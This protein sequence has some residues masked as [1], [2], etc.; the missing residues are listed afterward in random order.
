[1]TFGLDIAVLKTGDDDDLKIASDV[2]FLLS[3][4][5]QRSRARAKAIN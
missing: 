1:M 5:A 2:V 3:A 4:G